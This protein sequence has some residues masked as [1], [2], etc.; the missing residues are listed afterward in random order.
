MIHINWQPSTRDLRIFAV[1]QVLFFAVLTTAIV[2]RGGSS[3]LAI[4]LM[5]VS[6]ATGL[7]GTIQPSW[8]RPVYIGWMIAVFPLGWCVSYLSLGIVFWLV[9]VP[10][11]LVLRCCGV[12]PLERRMDRQRKTYWTNRPPMPAP[13]RY[14][15]KF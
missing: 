2:R 1:G 13:S 10:L 3:E 15:R 5:G 4:L 7:V 9:I 6:S 12:D 11:G 14:F 8:V